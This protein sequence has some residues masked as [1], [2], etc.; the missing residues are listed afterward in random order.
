[1]AGKS[2]G[3]LCFNGWSDFIPV[4]TKRLTYDFL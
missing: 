4:G 1:M 2:D 3:C